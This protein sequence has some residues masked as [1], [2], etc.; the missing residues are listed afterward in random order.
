MRLLVFLFD[1][2]PEVIASGEIHMARTPQSQW[3]EQL[4]RMKS[5]GLDMV[6]VY[7]F[8]IHHEEIENEYEFG[9][10]R[11]VSLFL[12][13]ANEVGL[14]VLARIGPWCHGEVR[15]GG[16]P[17]W[18]L[19]RAQKDGFALRN[20]NT[21]YMSYVKRWYTNLAKEMESHFF[22]D[23]GPIVAVQVDNETSDWKYLLALRSLALDVGI[24]PTFYTKTG[25]PPPEPNLPK[26]FPMLQFQGAYPDQFWNN[27]MKPTP[28]S[29]S[30][31]FAPRNQVQSAFPSLDVEIGGGMATAYNHRVRMYSEDM[32]SLHITLLGNGVNCLG[33]YMY[34][35]GTN[36]HS[37]VNVSDCPETTLQESSF[38][39]AG[40]QNPMNSMS[41]DFFAP[42]SEFGVPRAHYHQMR[43]LHLFLRDFGVRISPM[44]HIE[45]RVVQH[46]DGVCD[47]TTVQDFCL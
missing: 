18:V 30:Y 44:H 4:M 31:S 15:N 11:N 9:G 12:T 37:I 26:D 19:E 24:E 20:N 36:P 46:Y 7:F 45:V 35:G 27:E 47:R 21:D 39:P 32:P 6:A 25:W 28:S 40:A 29:G 8:W 34:H 43:R 23:G 17:D 22:K 13:T 38:Q 5:G 33:Y 41:Y 3:K 42:L 16:H 14:K 1:G 2:T 10:R